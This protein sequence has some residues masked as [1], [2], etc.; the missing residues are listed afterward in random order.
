M[1]IYVQVDD[2]DAHY[3]RAE[4]AGAR[5]VRPLANTDYG[6]REY[7]VYDSEDNLWSFG[8]YHPDDGE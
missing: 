7:S 2:I 4:A 6:A 5:I 3:A 8:T 1:G